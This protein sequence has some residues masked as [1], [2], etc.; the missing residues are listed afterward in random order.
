MKTVKRIIHN[1]ISAIVL[2]AIMTVLTF[3]GF[4]LFPLLLLIEFVINQTGSRLLAAMI[5]LVIPFAWII[6]LL[7]KLAAATIRD[8]KYWLYGLPIQAVVYALFTWIYFSH[9]SVTGHLICLIYILI[10]LSV[11]VAGLLLRR[12]KEKKQRQINKPVE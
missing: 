9:E 8:L 11:Q 2:I 1:N 3:A 7:I 12:H 5:C 6:A 10:A 4:I